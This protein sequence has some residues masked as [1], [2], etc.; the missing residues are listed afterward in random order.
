MKTKYTSKLF[1]SSENAT[2]ESKISFKLFK[3]S[4]AIGAFQ[5]GP[6]EK[7]YAVWF[8]KNNDPTINFIM[9]SLFVALMNQNQMILD[10][11]F[12]LLKSYFQPRQKVGPSLWIKEIFGNQFSASCTFG[13]Q[14]V[15]KGIAVWLI[16]SVE[17]IVYQ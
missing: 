11:N 16:K 14:E 1:G 2:S 17:N 13:G 8:S 4:K 12:L 9:G 7:M 6:M 15:T 10:Q 3:N 5:V